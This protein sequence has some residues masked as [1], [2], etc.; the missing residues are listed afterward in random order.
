[1]LIAKA[2]ALALL[3]LFALPAAAAATWVGLSLTQALHDLRAAGLKLVFSDQLVRPEMRVGVAPESSAPRRILDEILA[4]HELEAREGPRGTVVVVRRSAPGNTDSAPLPWLVIEEELIVVPSRVSLLR[5]APVAPLELSREEIVALPHL[6]DDAFRALSL[7]PGVAANDISAQFHVRGGRRDETLI[8]LDGQ[9]LYEAY[10]LKDY[11]GALSIVAPATLESVD[12]SSGGFSAEYGDRASGVLDMRTLTPAGPHRTRLG[13]GLLNANAGG[14]GVAPGDRGSWLVQLRRGSTDLAGRLL[15][16]EDPRYW[17][18]FGKLDSALGGSTRLQL[19]ALFSD[20]NLE[21]DEVDEESEKHLDTGYETSYFWL[22]QQTLLG[23]RLFFETALS[24]SRVDRDRNGVDLDEDVGFEIQD[25]RRLEVRSLRQAWNYQPGS[26]QA[27]KWGIEQREFDAGYDYFGFRRFDSP[28]T[29]A[30]GKPEEKT[31]LFRGRFEETHRSAYAADRFRVRG[32]L[33]AEVGLRYDR[34]SQ[35]SE[36]HLDPRLNLAWAIGETSVVRAAWGRVHQSQRP[37]ELG[38]EDGETELRSAESS[39]QSVLG[40]ERL[41]PLGARGS[42]VALRLEA[43]RREVGNPLSRFENLYE[44]INTFPEAEPDRVR[45]EPDRG[46]AEG[47]ELF[48]RWTTGERAT[49]W[50]NYAYATTEDEI[51]GRRVPRPFDQTH[52]LN[53][54][55]GIRLDRNWT[56]NLAWRYHTGWPT[57]PLSLKREVDDE[58]EVEFVPIFGERA[59]ARLA[60]YHR[61]D[62]RAS[63]QWRARSFDLT[64]FVDVQNLYDASNAAGFDY[65]IDTEAGTIDPNRE[66]WAGFLPSLGISFEF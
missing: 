64:F 30:L 21:F 45:V 3:A 66:D 48:V 17:D 53:V 32:R 28:L 18:A 40:F 27:L 39:H 54:D 4:P 41:L 51:S 14:A 6:G 56:L 20:D 47:I 44:P 29:D 60:D 15:G 12:L 46:I 42:V 57:T 9:E 13:I 65:A 59:S 24:R 49:W 63:R 5:Q 43:Y 19:D 22:I 37:Y 62:L 31:T 58:G 25:R 38:V 34:L 55:L 26:G 7:L 61:L 8:V 52:T 11:D 36:S 33:N 10:H 1:M 50:A 35:T 23:S 16:T 2:A